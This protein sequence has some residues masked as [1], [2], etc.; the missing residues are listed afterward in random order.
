[1][2]EIVARE[3]FG[4]CAQTGGQTSEQSLEAIPFAA[5]AG[6]DEFLRLGELHSAKHPDVT[7]HL[8]L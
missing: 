1:M 5:I 8:A 6:T 7:R 3:S 4:E 2:L